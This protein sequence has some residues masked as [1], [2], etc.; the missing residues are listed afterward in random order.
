MDAYNAEVRKLEGKFYGLEFH[1]VVCEHNMAADTLAKMGS[2]QAKVP[3]GV[4]IQDLVNPL[5]KQEID[6]GPEQQLRTKEANAGN[7]VL[8]CNTPGV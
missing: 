8:V 1:H 6:D 3:L 5:V 2:T 7:E 4:S